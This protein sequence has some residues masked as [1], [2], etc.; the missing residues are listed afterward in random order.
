MTA[1]PP[2]AIGEGLREHAREQMASRHGIASLVRVGADQ[3]ERLEY[4][5]TGAGRRKRDDPSPAKGADER[6]APDGRVVGEILLGEHAPVRTDRLHERAPD[7]A[8][9]EALCTFACDGF[10]R[11]RQVRL[12]DPEL[13]PGRAAVVGEEDGAQARVGGQQAGA[14]GDLT[15]EMRGVAETE[16]LAC[17]ADGRRQVTRQR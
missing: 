13:G 14:A 5:A 10:Q 6:L 2:G 1:V 3:A 15:G 12:H 8:R 11:A 9:V 16:A 4:H 7:R 17:E